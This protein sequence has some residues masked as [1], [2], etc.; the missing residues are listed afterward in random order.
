MAKEITSEI[1]ASFTKSLE[2]HPI[3]EA[4]ATIEDL[5]FF[6]EHH[7]SSVWYFMSLIKYLQSIVSP[8]TYPWILLRDASIWLNFHPEI[9][10]SFA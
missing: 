10:L 6:M 1:I 5:Q 8:T 9:F 4:V 7:G 2:E 3:Y